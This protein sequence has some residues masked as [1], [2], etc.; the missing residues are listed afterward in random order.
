MLVA[1]AV[2]SMLVPMIYL[3]GRIQTPGG[4]EWAF[5]NRDRE[6]A[7]PAYAARAQRAHVNLTENLAGFAILVLVAH[8][9]GKANH[10]TALGAEM[11][12]AARVAHLLVYT[13]G[14]TMVR[15]AVFFLGTAGEILI[16][17]QL[18]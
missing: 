4:V 2:L 12:F 9:A 7:V 6:L 17:S 16:L 14:I 8:V 11:F 3:S 13:A 18:F 10:L 1:T 15:T 5:G